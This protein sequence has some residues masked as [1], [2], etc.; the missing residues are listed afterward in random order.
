RFPSCAV[1][2]WCTKRTASCREAP[3]SFPQAWT[4]RSQT[5]PTRSVPAAGQRS[6]DVLNL[7]AQLFDLGLDFEREPRDFEPFRFVAWSL[8][9]KRVRFALHFL[10]KKIELLADVARIGEQ[11]FELL[12]VAAQAGDLF[13]HVTAL[14]RNRSFLRKPRWIELRFAEQF[15]QA[16][17]QAL[18]KGTLRAFG[19]GFSL[20]SKLGNRA[21][22]LRHFDAQSVRFIGPH[23]IEFIE[24]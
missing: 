17:F 2:G 1:A 18:G 13:A 9:E 24:R 6:F 20:R 16:R 19:N 22:P 3:K 7:L 8:R 12:H 21:Q 11:R 4:S 15:L 14:R 10:Q 5:A 23:A